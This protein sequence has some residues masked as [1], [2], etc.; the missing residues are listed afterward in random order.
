MCNCTGNNN[1]NDYSKLTANTGIAQ[2]STANSSVTGNGAVPVLTSP[3]LVFKGTLVRSVIIKA[4]QPVTMG[5]IRLFVE[6][7]GEKSLY[8]EIPVSVTPSLNA[9]PTP[10]PVLP[11]FEVNLD[12]GLKLESGYVLMA[13][14]LTGQTF[15]IVAEGLDWVYPDPIPDTCCNFKQEE[16]VNG[17]K[18]IST[19]N[20]NLDGTG[21][22]DTIYTAPTGVNGAR[23]KS[24][25]IKALQG[26]NEGMVRLYVGETSGTFRLI[27]EIYIPQTNPGA[28]DPFF[29]QVVELDFNLKA[30][31]LLGASTQNAESFAL[32]VESVQ[33]TYPI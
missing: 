21:V 14:T 13:T 7:G 18:T 32:T 28:F 11:T 1:H 24:V 4:I 31:Y 27:K 23:I 12:G 10:T 25:T 15:N 2:V 29:K 19:A 3:L 16:A 20:A 5:M 26:T 6:G 33:W 30:T 8:K 17:L 9:T 22:V